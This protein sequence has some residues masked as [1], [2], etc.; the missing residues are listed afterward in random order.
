MLNM[1]GVFQISLSSIGHCL[2]VCALR[3]LTR[4]EW[5]IKSD[6]YQYLKTIN[7]NYSSVDDSIS[8]CAIRL[9]SSGLF[10]FNSSYHFWLETV[11]DSFSEVELSHSSPLLVLFFRYKI[12]FSLISDD[13]YSCYCSVLRHALCI[14]WLKQMCSKRYK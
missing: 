11:P 5:P 13:S 14:P 7:D 4:P 6:F 10:P 12:I 2:A 3:M 8:T 9:L 1:H